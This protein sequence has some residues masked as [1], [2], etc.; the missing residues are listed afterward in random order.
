MQSS[1]IGSPAVETTKVFVTY[2]SVAELKPNP[3]NARTHS[4]HQLKLIQASIREFGFTNPLLV[5]RNLKVIAG[6]GRLEAAKRLGITE[7]PTVCL[8]DLTDDQLRAYALADNEIAN[9]GGYDLDILAEELDY[10]FSVESSFDVTVT[11]FAMPEID[12]ILSDKKKKSTEPDPGDIPIEVPSV[13]ASKLGDLWILGRHR[14]MCGDT[15]SNEVMQHLMNGEKAAAVFTDPPYGCKIDGHV[16]GLGKVKHREFEVGAG[17]MTDDEFA[18]FLRQICRQLA[19]HTVSGSVHYLCIDWRKVQALLSVGSAV[20]DA[21]LNIAVWQKTSPGMGSFYRSQHEL[22]CIFRNGNTQHRN[23]VALGR[24]GRNRTNCWS[25]PSINAFARQTEEGR[26]G[27]LH[28]TVKP[29]A[30]VADALLDCTARGDLVLDGFLG[31]GTTVIAAEKVGRRCCGVELDPLYVDVI[32]RRWQLYSGDQAIHAE[33]GLTFDD[34]AA[35]RAAD[36]KG[37]S[38]E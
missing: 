4:K 12:L 11:G 21:L 30:L 5:D 3:Q 22:I 31:S 26:L 9:K 17:E 2:R 1:D 24:F 32:V 27:L 16:S 6:N 10:L 14:V 15:R 37:V 36:A 7:L 33:T 8:H 19:A 35:Q 20:Y 23:N 25:Y 29:V 28:P 34:L 13:A 18:N 38:H